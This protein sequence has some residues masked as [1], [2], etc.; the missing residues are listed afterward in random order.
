MVGA[1]SQPPTFIQ[2]QIKTLAEN[3]ARVSLLPDS[4]SHKY[5]RTR[6]ARQGFTFQL[7]GE[8]KEL[9]RQAD[10]IHFQWPG[11]Y[12]AYQAL[13]K[14]F[15]KPAVLSLRGRQISILPH[16]QGNERYRRQLQG[17]LADCAAYHCVSEAIKG[18]AVDFGADP[19]RAWVIRPAV[20]T[21]FFHPPDSRPEAPPFEIVMVG[22]LMWR[23]GYEF[24]LAAVRLLK[25]SGE[26]FR[27]T[28]VGQ[29]PDEARIEQA[30]KDFDL[31]A[32][33]RLLNGL[34]PPGVRHLLHR[35]HVFLHTSL[36]EGI[37][38]AVVEAMACG[39]PVVTSE[40]GGMREAVTDGAQGFVIPLRD[41]QAAACRLKQIFRSPDLRRTLGRNARK[42]A[43]AEFELN[44]QGARFIE[45]YQ[46]VMSQ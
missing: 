4:F 45:L 40:A 19:E 7:P 8:M 18:E 30:V 44:Y 38:N 31:S 20:D 9:A 2:R 11:H 21:G 6:L 34:S 10:L 28:I 17:A 23:K 41:P 5:L 15:H 25:E 1:G 13:A 35:S 16:L 42:K 36:S 46:T 39:L 12:L 32:E 43:T 26:L 3:Q 29:G 33:V 37:S 27:L 14:K 22:A 24:A